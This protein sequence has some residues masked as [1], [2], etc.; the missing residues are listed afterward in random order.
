MFIP[1]PL[2]ETVKSKVLEMAKILHSGKIV[3]FYIKSTV[4]FI[5]V[6]GQPLARAGAKAN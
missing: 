4:W 2:G 3:N 5:F 1:F 6:L